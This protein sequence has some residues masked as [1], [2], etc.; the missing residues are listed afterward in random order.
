MTDAAAAACCTAAAEAVR[1]HGVMRARLMHLQRR[2]L[3]LSMVCVVTG[4]SASM[5][6]KSQCWWVGSDTR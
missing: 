5:V 4:G 1:C 2:R 3:A 6:A